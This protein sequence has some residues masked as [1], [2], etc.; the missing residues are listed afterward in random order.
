[1][2]GNKDTKESEKPRRQ[3]KLKAKKGDSVVEGLTLRAPYNDWN[4]NNALFDTPVKGKAKDNDKIVFHKCAIWYIYTLKDGS[5]KKSQ[6][7]IEFPCEKGVHA[8]SEYGVTEVLESAD[9]DDKDG[10]KK[11][12]KPAAEVKRKGTGKYKI[13]CQLPANAPD[14]DKLRSMLN[15]LYVK[16]LE[17]MFKHGNFKPKE[18]EDDEGGGSDKGKVKD[19]RQK[20]TGILDGKYMLPEGI[21]GPDNVSDSMKMHPVWYQTTTITDKRGS[22][23]TKVDYSLPS[24]IGLSVETKGRRATKFCDITHLDE[25]TSAVPAEDTPTKNVTEELKII[26]YE[27]VMS[28]QGIRHIPL[29]EVTEL[30]IG[31]TTK[32]RLNCRSTMILEFL[33]GANIEQLGY[34]KERM[35]DK[36]PIDQSVLYM[37]GQRLQDEL[38]DELKDD[39]GNEKKSESE[40][41]NSESGSP[42]PKTRNTSVK[43]IKN[44]RHSSES[45]SE[46]SREPEPK[47]AVNNRKGESYQES[48]E[49]S[50]RSNRQSIKENSVIRES[51]SSKR[52]PTPPTDYS[53]SEHDATEEDMSEQE[54]LPPPAPIKKTLAVPPKKRQVRA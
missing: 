54:P 38:K 12:S 42:S 6:L 52:R 1:M 48:G 17:H 9:K 3:L 27:D 49:G 31:A 24:T 46:R 47:K 8:I 41:E 29:M 28:P 10:K 16:S 39:E 4:V 20:G 51:T 7:K 30:F 37:A 44:K 34:L 50:E 25:D 43:S 22:P 23:V 36:I 32:L 11:K 40:E 53:K 5:T 45:G 18:D 15:E 14:A 2:K 26:S 35:G 21:P 13:L 33:T 19:Q